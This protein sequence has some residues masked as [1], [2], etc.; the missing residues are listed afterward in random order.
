MTRALAAEWAPLGIRVNAIAP[1]YFRTDLTEAF[2]R[3]RGLAGGDAGK[4]PQ[5]R[6]GQFDDL[7]GAAVYLL[8]G[9]CALCHRPVPAGRRRHARLA[10]TS[11][12]RI[13]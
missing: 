12:T 13:P 10:L 2:Y 8:L 5:G 9:R 1:G 11:A 3:G 6:F 7:V 4:I